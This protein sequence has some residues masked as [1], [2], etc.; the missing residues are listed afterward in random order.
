[1]PTAANPTAARS[2][3]WKPSTSATGIAVP[4]WTASSVCVVAIVESAAMP[5]A[6]P[7]CCVVLIRPEASPASRRLDARERRDRDRHEREAEPEPDQ[8]E[9][10]QQVT[11]VRPADRDL[12]EVDEARRSAPS[13]RRRAPA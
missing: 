8:Q 2:A 4:A 3:S 1:M 13:S 10:G 11:E 7:I 9:P 12:R 5:S 6:P